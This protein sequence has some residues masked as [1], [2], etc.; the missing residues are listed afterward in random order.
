MTYRVAHRGIKP[1]DQVTDMLTAGRRA[2]SLRVA[3]LNADPF[4][5]VDLPSPFVG[6][7][8]V[9]E[10]VGL[11][12]YLAGAVLRDGVDGLFVVAPLHVAVFV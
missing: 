4:V 7:A 5:G 10:L 9:E 2:D 8:F 1:S 12:E 6:L 11:F 3:P